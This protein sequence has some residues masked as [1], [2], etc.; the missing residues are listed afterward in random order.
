MGEKLHMCNLCRI[1]RELWT[2]IPTYLTIATWLLA[3]EM[4][5]LLNGHIYV[6]ARLCF[7]VHLKKIKFFCVSSLNLHLLQ[8]WVDF[9]FPF[10]LFT[11]TSDEAF[12]IVWH[13]K[14]TRRI[15]RKC[16]SCLRPICYRLSNCFRIVNFELHVMC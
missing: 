16:C 10:T 13:Q 6:Y 4:N 7:F 1:Y 2:G 11:M 3:C 9:P 14:V 8:I 12:Y 15:L 5:F